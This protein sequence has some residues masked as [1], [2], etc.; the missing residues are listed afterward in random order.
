MLIFD[1]GGATTP[2]N[3]SKSSGFALSMMASQ[4]QS[5]PALVKKGFWSWMD[6]PGGPAVG[7]PETTVTPA[8][9]GSC[10][11]HGNGMWTGADA[12]GRRGGH[13]LFLQ[14][15]AAMASKPRVVLLSQWNEFAGQP[16]GG[17]CK[18]R[19]SSTCALICGRLA[20]Q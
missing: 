10:P 16:N 4:L 7:G 6:G 5:N 19:A 11:P 18:C 9:F 13:T 17:G 3:Y 8:Y 12:V 20:D 15:A 14:M 1:G 2:A